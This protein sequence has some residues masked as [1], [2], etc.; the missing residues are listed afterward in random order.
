MD[1]ALKIAVFVDKGMMH[2]EGLTRI[3]LASQ[4]NA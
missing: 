1:G 3:I 4:L 2:A